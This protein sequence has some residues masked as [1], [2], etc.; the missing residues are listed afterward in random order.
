MMPRISKFTWNFLRVLKMKFALTTA[1][2]ICVGIVTLRS[3]LKISKI[4]FNGNL[5]YVILS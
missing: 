4:D 1:T 3:F 5:T 2:I